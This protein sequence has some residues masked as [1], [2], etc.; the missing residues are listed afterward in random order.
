MRQQKLLDVGNNPWTVNDEEWVREYAR[1][2][3]ILVSF[4]DKGFA[5]QNRFTVP[6]YEEMVVFMKR[7]A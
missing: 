2:T 4:L 3:P 6:G 1:D 5:Q 7:Q